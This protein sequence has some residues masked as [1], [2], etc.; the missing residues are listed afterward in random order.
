[1]TP[2]DEPTPSDMLLANAG[3][4]EVD[5]LQLLLGG[6]THRA[7]QNQHPRHETTACGLIVPSETAR[8]GMQPEKRI[9]CPRC[10]KETAAAAVAER[11]ADAA[12]RCRR[13]EVRE[14]ETTATPEATTAG[15][16]SLF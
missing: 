5:T 6:W 15:R 11:A 4:D 12:A 10:R 1:M 9:D 7:T 8:V 13:P 2:D 3:G 14:V 16:N